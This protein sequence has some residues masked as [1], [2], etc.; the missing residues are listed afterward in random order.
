MNFDEA[1][2]QHKAAER[3]ADARQR[4]GAGDVRRAAEQM[5]AD[6]EQHARDMIAYLNKRGVRPKRPFKTK[7]TIPPGYIIERLNLRNDVSRADKISCV[8]LLPD[9]RIVVWG[10][11]GRGHKGRLFEDRDDWVAD[12]CVVQRISGVEFSVEAIHGTLQVWVGEKFNDFSNPLD[13]GEV[14]VRYAQAIER[15]H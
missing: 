14:F 4:S 1:M 2:R 11:S 15:N 5:R 10:N 9:L 13:M 6:F 8:V 7:L 12:D 3:A